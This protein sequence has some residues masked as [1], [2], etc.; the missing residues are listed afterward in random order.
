M[1]KPLVRAAV[2]DIGNVLVDWHPEAA[3]LPEL[4]SLAAVQDFLARTDFFARNLRADAGAAWADLAAEIADPADRALF[5]AYPS[6]FAGCIPNAIEPSWQA[7]AAL[8]AAGLAIHAITNW[9]AETWPLGMAA[10]PRLATAFGVTVV[11]GREGVLKPDPRIF[12]LLCTRTGLAPQD[13]LFIDDSAKNIQGAAD[14]GMDTLHFTGPA[15][16]RDGLIQR[17]LPFHA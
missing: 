16:L 17:G 10:H 3:F 9:S 15:A 14:F 8:R 5:A 2:F 11:S 12:N 6:R 7:M 4:G 1:P 13:C